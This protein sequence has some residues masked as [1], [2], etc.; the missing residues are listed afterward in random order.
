MKKL[1]MAVALSAT[2]LQAA[3]E[4]PIITF[5]T[6]LYDN[7]GSSNAFHFY[8]GATQ[9][10]Y[11]D[12]DF[13]FG[14]VEQLV[15]PAP[16][17]DQ[18]TTI[19]G[20][21]G[22]DGIV[23][24]YGDASLVDYLDL[25]GLYMTNLDISQ[26]TNLDVLNLNHNELDALDL[27]PFS[28]LQALYISDNPF[29]K[30]PVVIGGNKPGLVILEMSHVGALDQSF[31]L[32][33]YP[34]LLSFDA[35]STHDF[36]VCDP[37]GCPDLIR[38]SMDATSVESVDITK[39][40]ALRILNISETKIT[41]IDL[42]KSPAIT[43]FYCTH[44]GYFNS[45]YKLKSVDVSKLPNLIRFACQDNLLTSLD[46]SKNPLL[47]SLF[48]NG[49]YL[50]SIDI[51]AN[52]YLETLDI[53]RNLMDFNTMPL[54]Q[55]TFVEYNY[56]QRPMPLAR[57]FAVGQEID[58]TSRVIRPE[59]DYE[60]Y[61]TVFAQRRDKEGQ[62][63]EEELA[64]SLGYYTY[65]NGKV[66]FLKECADSVYMAFYCTA[67]PQQ[68]LQT[69]PFMVKSEEAYGKPSPMISLRTKPATKKISFTVGVRGA[70]AET[71]K[72]FFVDFGSGELVKFTDTGAG[73]TVPE[74][75][76]SGS[77]MRTVY[78]SEG[79]D[80]AYFAISGYSLQSIDV[81]KA[82]SLENLVVKNCVLSTID[83]SYNKY[84]RTID[85]SGNA[86]TSLDLAGIDPTAYKT[87]LY[88]LDASNNRL[89]EL[90][91]GL[92]TLVNVDL[93]NNLL[94][95]IDL[96]KAT[97]VVSL[98]LS[99]NLLVEAAVNDLESLENLNLSNNNL[100]Q[101]LVPDYVPFKS[102]DL[103]LNKFALSQLPQLTLANYAYAP[104]KAVE[105]PVKAPTANLTAQL[106]ND[107]TV[108]SWFKADGSAVSSDDIS[109]TYPGVF[110]FNNTELGLV[111]CTFT[112]ATFPGL[113]GTTTQVEVAPMPTNVISSFRTLADGIGRFVITG[114]A[115]LYVDWGGNGAVEQYIAQSQYT[116]YE[117]PVTANATVNVYSYEPDPELTVFS[118]AAGPMAEFDGSKMTKLTM[119]SLTGS[120]LA[121]ENL[122]LPKAELTELSIQGSALTSAE[123]LKDYPK[124]Y[125]LTLSDNP[126]LQSL[127]LSVLKGLGWLYATGNSLKEVKFDNPILESVTL[128]GN[129]LETVDFTGAENIEQ[130]WV[131]NNKLTSVNVSALS[132]LRWLDVTENCLNF[133][134]LPEP[135]ETMIRYAYGNQYPVDAE[136]VDGVI[137]LSKYGATSWRWFIN[138]PYFDEEGVLCGE[139]LIEND[140]YFIKEGVTT[141][142]TDFS[143]V[144]C[145]MQNPDFPDL[146][147]QTP[148]LNV[149]I[150][151]AIEEVD[152]DAQTQKFY[153]L[154]G[155]PV[156]SPRKGQFIIT[157]NAKRVG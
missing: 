128:A 72:D 147:L 78:V 104:Q 63:Y 155:R 124:L 21:V 13:G 67:F 102:L 144:I 46:I 49:N 118:L 148:F 111:Y 94:V 114:D 98:D 73:F 39:N 100:T 24:I 93:S 84:L 97:Q 110:R 25:E 28:R 156:K 20:S 6:N 47:Q 22:P 17:A 108:F 2:L 139:E 71:P 70:S 92:G 107:L 8:M 43:E 120:K 150:P 69:T 53:S 40:Q 134:T 76:I 55:E 136:M 3:A 5:R 131:F 29:N 10:A 32:S 146:Y 137:D 138:A 16:S 119:F 141:F 30:T 59:T 54:P 58:L 66:T 18:A 52:P 142:T 113:V 42:S 127:D 68:D 79:D 85:L 151:G 37:S 105:L 64:D 117:V 35:Y 9:E 145:V 61:F 143:N 11:F 82:T 7:A 90:T 112:N 48:C 19:Q 140:E 130:L 12:V 41:E 154:Q 44:S 56:K 87:F 149:R 50:T 34:A 26:L 80:L 96:S 103:S 123:F 121:A 14:P 135:R 101:L 153:D 27:T 60:T 77:A 75:A 62:P 115:E 129:Q 38:L 74:T 23:K 86:L 157:R 133:L 1:F 99:N 45:D 15:G 88:A 31:N 4:E 125:V 83:L 51:T 81:T 33:D 89:S 152:A 122:I 132:K 36:R 109:E 106:L 95:N 126:N 57:S 116:A 91:P 65:N